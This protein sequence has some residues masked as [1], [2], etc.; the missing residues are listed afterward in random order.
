M[1][2][3]IK[4]PPRLPLGRRT[5]LTPERQQ[6]IVTAVSNGV[7]FSMACRLVGKG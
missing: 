2:R 3:G 4:A 7:P 5:R 6:M 1:A